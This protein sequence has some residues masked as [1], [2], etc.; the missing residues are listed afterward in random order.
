MNVTDNLRGRFKA[1]WKNRADL[2][3]L[4]TMFENAVTFI[5]APKAMKSKLEAPGTLNSRGVEEALRREL[6]KNVVPELRRILRVVNERKAAIKNERAVL[7][8]PKID[9]TD[10]A[11]TLR[12]QE[13]RGYFRSL[14]LGD[15]IKVL[16][17]NPD[18][19]ML[20]AA[21]EAPAALSGLTA[22]MRA[23]VEQAYVLANH[24]KTLKAMDDREEALDVVGAA[25]EIAVMEI[26]SSVGLE[27]QAFDGWFVAADG[28]EAQRAA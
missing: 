10:L 27:P 12:R 15:R 6:G 11:A 19:T 1:A 22:E 14:E 18:P 16:L 20:A 5:A 23:H 26:R 2:A 21:L 17:D 25:A 9:S 3:G 4:D 24:A 28:T 7:A 13:I 8:T